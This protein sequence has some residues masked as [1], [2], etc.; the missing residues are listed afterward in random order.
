MLLPIWLLIALLIKIDSKGPVLHKRKVVGKGGKEFNALKFRTMVANADEILNNDSSLREKFCSN[1]KLE[2]D[3]RITR[4]GTLLRKTS[5]DEIPQFFNVLL[6]QMSLVG[7][8]MIVSEELGKYKEY[9]EERLMVK[10]GISGLWQVSGRSRLS[11][12][13]RVRLDLYYIDNRSLKL[14]LKILLK[15]IPAVLKGDGAC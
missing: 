9:A 11:Y 8:R 5:F 13:E 4:I 12:K 15:T 2:N 6:G 1:F 10:P 14:D 3:N 7:P